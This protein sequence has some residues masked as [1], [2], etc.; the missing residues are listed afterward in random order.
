MNML[1]DLMC[2]QEETISIGGVVAI[3]DLQGV[4]MGHAMQMTPV[5]FSF[6]LFFTPALDL[7][8]LH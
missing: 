1:V 8:Y 7:T 5:R 2:L 3:V 6:S 4:G